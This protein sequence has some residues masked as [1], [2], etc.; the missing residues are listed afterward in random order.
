M[1]AQVE[2][3]PDCAELG[4][5]RTENEPAGPGL[6]DCTQAHQA[7]LE[8]HVNHCIIQTVVHTAAL[9][10]GQGAYLGVGVDDSL[11]ARPVAP[12][13]ND[14]AVDHNHRAHRH[15]AFRCGGRGLGQRH[16]H[17]VNV[18]RV[19]PAHGAVHPLII[20]GAGTAGYNAQRVMSTDFTRCEGCG[21]FFANPGEVHTHCPKC[22][23]EEPPP[24]SPREILRLLKNT[25]RDSQSRG[26]FLTVDELSQ[27]TNVPGNKI[28][29]YIH[30][31]QIDTASF[32][33]P[34]VRAFVARRQLERM[35][36]THPLDPHAET[37]GKPDERPARREGGFHL[38]KDD[39]R[40]S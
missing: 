2:A 22:R 8:R 13:T 37:P 1:P 4:L 28:W 23:H 16:A 32:D 25:L 39:D 20:D 12:P 33:D 15:L 17:K 34:A 40:D 7:R 31:G 35:R 6:V 36:T 5:R 30:T 21:I 9:S 10:R 38:K 11:A 14:L 3:A 27:R 24:T 18:L 29:E 26:E 19:W